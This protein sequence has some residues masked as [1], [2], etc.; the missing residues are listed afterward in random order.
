MATDYTE[1]IA[2]IWPTIMQAWV[3]HAEKCPVIE[4]DIVERQVKAYD[5]REYLQGLSTRTRAATRRQFKQVTA[6][7]GMMV[8]IRDSNKRALQ[9]HAF[10]PDDVSF[11]LPEI[12]AG[13]KCPPPQVKLV[14]PYTA[15]QGQYLAFIYYYSKIHGMAPSEADMQKYFRVSPPSVHQMVVTLAER[16]LISRE[17]G[18]A[19]S[20]KLL[21]ERQD[22]P[23]L[24]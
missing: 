20:I 6:A 21:M 11:L 13:P 22:L 10:M 8:F 3:E 24:E 4:C 17:P 19:R 2:E 16:G 9:S 7:G 5:S 12:E 1:Q 23:D 14:A 15:K 18:K